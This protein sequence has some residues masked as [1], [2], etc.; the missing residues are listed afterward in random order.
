MT[1]GRP[2]PSQDAMQCQSM[3]IPYVPHVPPATTE[4]YIAP[5]LFFFCTIE[6]SI[7]LFLSLHMIKQSIIIYFLLY[8]V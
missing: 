6:R 7:V 1:S 3:S 2:E 5:S 4:Y 8:C